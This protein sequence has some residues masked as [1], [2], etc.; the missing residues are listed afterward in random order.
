M[1]LMNV[2]GTVDSLPNKE[3]VRRRV[4]NILT[5]IF[6]NYGYLPLDTSILCYYDLLA[7]K[8]AGGSEILKEVYTLK[9]QGDRLLGLRYD[10]TVPFSKVISINAGKEITLPFKRYE[11]GKVFRDGPVKTGRAREFYQC[12]VD[13]C[14][15][16]GSYIEAEMLAM[17]VE[18]YRR[19]GIDVEIEINNRK[20]LEGFIIEAG[21][22]KE[23]SSKVILSVDKL[24]KIGE[25][26]VRRELADYNIDD[27]KL[28]KLFSLFKCNIDDLDNS[29]ITNDSFIEGRNEI[30]E[31]FGYIN[32]LELTECKFTPYLARG[33]EIYTG[34]VW[35]VFDK[36]KRITSA[37]GG[38]GR[39]DKIIT[40]FIDDGN[41][42]PAVGISFG[43]VPICEILNQKEEVSNIYDLL[44]VPMDTKSVS[45][46]LANKLREK[47]IKVIIEMSNRKIKKV[48][49]TAN[50]NNIPYVIILGGNEIENKKLDIKNMKE[51]TVTSVDI[52]DIEKMYEIIK[53][54]NKY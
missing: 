7:S 10:L 40:N 51:G 42:Y 43:L 13:V 47:N 1:K 2:K 19:L 8:Y 30:K 35:E 12:D 54:S 26:G 25:D 37:I 53:N 20:L 39:Y 21:I 18:C 44:I 28:N 4:V 50:R 38:G 49:E 16:E 23:L 17:T 41:S 32:D 11:V 36:E 31:L 29:N 48:L 3:I 5:S 46:K 34:T 22:S 45:L 33:L 24:A 6:E 52:D 15:I 27:D 14:G 9:D